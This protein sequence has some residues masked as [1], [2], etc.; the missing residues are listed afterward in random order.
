MKK[1]FMASLA[2][3]T[4]AI[5]LTLFQMSSCKKADAEPTTTPCD[6]VCSIIGNYSGTFTNQNNLTDPFGYILKEN[7]F[8]TSAATL[9]VSPTAFGGYSNS[10]DSVILNSW[11]SIN[12]NYYYFAGKLSSDKRTITGIY[13]NLTT[14]S[15]IG[16]FILQKQ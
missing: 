4:L 9:G 1:I 12:S 14:T 10:C 7:N 3:T 16:T 8:A 15:E 6:P 13:K 11:N 2:L 5:A